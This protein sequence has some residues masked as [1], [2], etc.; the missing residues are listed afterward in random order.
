MTPATARRSYDEWKRSIDEG[1]EVRLSL[2]EYSEVLE[3]LASLVAMSAPAREDDFDLSES[4]PKPET[5][6]FLA[7]WHAEVVNE[8]EALKAAG[9][10]ITLFACGAFDPV[11]AEDVLP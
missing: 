9:E 5:S 1:P 7:E 4:L 6:E 10:T 2:H 8:A 11:V 3:S